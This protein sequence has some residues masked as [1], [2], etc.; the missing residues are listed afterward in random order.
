MSGSYKPLP[1]TPPTT[2]PIAVAAVRPF[3]L[4]IWLPIAAPMMA[5]PSVRST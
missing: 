3:P 2:A 1:I 4:P 5:P